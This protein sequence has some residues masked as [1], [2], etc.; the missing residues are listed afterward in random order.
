MKFGFLGVGT[1][2]TELFLI[3]VLAN[4]ALNP[5]VW[6]LT[7]CL[8]LFLQDAVSL[9]KMEEDPEAAARKL[10]ETAFSRGSGDN[11]TCIVVKFEHDKPGGGG[12]SPPGDK[13][14]FHLLLVIRFAGVPFTL[15]RILLAPSMVPPAAGTWGRSWFMF[16]ACLVYIYATNFGLRSVGLP[17]GSACPF[18]CLSWVHR[19]IRH[20]CRLVVAVACCINES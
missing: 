18:A 8:N 5:L 2:S 12:Y 7:D 1:K 13:S 6:W 3:G 9:V 20:C 14:W 15:G 11:I 17:A 19:P 10:T 16:V 4:G